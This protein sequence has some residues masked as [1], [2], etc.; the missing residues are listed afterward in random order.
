MIKKS[1][2][3]LF[4]AVADRLRDN[5]YSPVPADP[6]TKACVLRNAKTIASLAARPP[7]PKTLDDWVSR[8]PYHLCGVVCGNVVALDFDHDDADRN[9]DAAAHAQQ[10]FGTTLQVIGRPGRSKLLYRADQFDGRPAG[11]GEWLEILGAR[12]HAVVFGPHPAGGA[13]R[14]VD[15]SPLD[16][17]LSDLPTVSRDRIF[18]WLAEMMPTVSGSESSAR[19]LFRSLIADALECETV[20]ELR[21]IARSRNTD[22]LEPDRLERVVKGLWTKRLDGELWNDGIARVV[23]PRPDIKRLGNDS[24]ALLLLMNLQADRG[25]NQQQFAISAKAMARAQ[26]IPGWK[27]ERYRDVRRRL[28]AMGFLEETYHGGKGPGDPSQYRFV[29]KGENLV[30]Q[31]NNDSPPH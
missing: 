8:Y 7:S 17:P 1:T 9:H 12:M 24:D 6:E 3:R 28:V 30:P 20:D 26:V 13:Y 27:P 18:G 31:Y 11:K 23:I 5:G 16:V 4:G 19:E 15:E 29:K 25:G 21:D 10:R 2:P 14:W 22:N